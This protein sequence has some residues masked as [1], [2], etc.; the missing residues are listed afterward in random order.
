MHVIVFDQY[1]SASSMSYN[2]RGNASLR[3]YGYKAWKEFFQCEDVLIQKEIEDASSA[4]NCDANG[5]VLVCWPV[6]SLEFSMDQFTG[7]AAC[8]C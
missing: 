7:E 4:L 2:G 6:V 1:W 5:E 3:I 8:K